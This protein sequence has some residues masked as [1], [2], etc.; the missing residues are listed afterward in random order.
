M[1]KS[2]LRGLSCFL[3]LFLIVTLI[4]CGSVYAGPGKAQPLR[5]AA[6]VVG[7]LMYA[8]GGGLAGVVEKNSSLKM[9]VLP[10]G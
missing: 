7:S 6:N 4:P 1:K 5:L 10:Q 8:V 9:E 2:T 3:Y